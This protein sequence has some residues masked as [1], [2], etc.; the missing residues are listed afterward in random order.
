MI[1]PSYILM[2]VMIVGSGR[3]AV[4]QLQSDSSRDE[5]IAEL[6]L[7]DDEVLEADSGKMYYGEWSIRLHQCRAASRQKR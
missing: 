5:I 4:A 6:G 2:A 3:D 7:P 1:R